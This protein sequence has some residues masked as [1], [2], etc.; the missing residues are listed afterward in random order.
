MGTDVATVVIGGRIV[1]ED[2]RPMTIDVEALYG[3]VR[4]FCAKGL[5][6]AQRARADL[7]ARIKPHVQAWY[8]SWHETMLDRPFYRVNSRT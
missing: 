4:A 1:V 5:T 2:H 8:D 3:E 7:L 6:P